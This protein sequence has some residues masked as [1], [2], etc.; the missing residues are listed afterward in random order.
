MFLK[1]GGCMTIEGDVTLVEM[2]TAG[3]PRKV[4]RNQKMRIEF[5]APTK[6]QGVDCFVSVGNHPTKIIWFGGAPDDLIGITHVT[7]VSH[8]QVVI[9]ASL[10]TFH[11]QPKAIAGG[12][13]FYV[14]AA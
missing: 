13:S 5:E 7:I 12:V 11:G 4:F 6:R 8:G 1:Q 14:L 10:N 2:S 9:D 3:N